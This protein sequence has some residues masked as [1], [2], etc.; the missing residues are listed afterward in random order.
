[1]THTGWGRADLFSIGVAACLLL[2]LVVKEAE[3]A[4]GRASEIAKRFAQAR[5]DVAQ[6][7]QAWWI[8]ADGVGGVSPE[9]LAFLDECGVPA[10]PKV[11]AWTTM[12]RLHGRS[13]RG[14]R[15][16]RPRSGTGPGLPCWVRS[17]PRAL[18]A[19]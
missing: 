9:R 18:W 13:P 3:P 8:K 6:A 16:P 11:C 2:L 1:M 17:E 15:A 19:R 4:G 12:S 7:R 10:K 5:E 14:A